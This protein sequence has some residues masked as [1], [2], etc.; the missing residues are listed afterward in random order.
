MKRFHVHV[1]VADLDRSIGFYSTLFGAEPSV[2]KP[3][4]AKW[5]L[6]DPRVDFAI[7]QRDS[8]AGVDHL[9]F[10]V[11][12]ADELAEIGARLASAQLPRETQDQ[13]ACC[14]ARS[15]KHW[16]IDPQGVAW[17]SFHTLDSVPV[18]GDDLS[19]IGREGAS[20]CVPGETESA[21][22]GGCCGP[23]AKAA[24]AGARCCA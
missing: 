7:S 22:Q 23:A 6:E 20:C 16:T 21:A 12:S 9:G 5:M 1:S 15:N 11:E 2:R 10:Q 24:D 17:E 18:Y 4:Y 8:E 14:Y 13:A 3:D 19:T